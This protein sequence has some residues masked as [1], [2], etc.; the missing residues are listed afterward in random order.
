MKLAIS[1]IA[2]EPAEDAKVAGLM[3]AHGFAGVE[4]APTKYWPQ[5]LAAGAADIAAVRGFWERRGLPIIAMQSLLFGTQGLALFESEAKRRATRDYLAGILAL[6]GKLGAKALVFGSPKNRLKGAL[7]DDQAETIAVPFFRALGEVAVHHHTYLCV[8]PNPAAYGC[9]WITTSA[10]GLALVRK[11][12]H[13]GFGLHLD[14]AGMTL[15]GEDLPEAIAAADRAIRHFHASEAQLAPL[16]KGG[17]D[18]A[19]AAGALRSAG[20]TGWVSI[21]ML[22]TGTADRMAAVEKALD[23]AAAAYGR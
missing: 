22:V 13:P 5:P 8:E 15:A 10:Q 7:T 19:A 11:V 17:T 16:G 4:I 12:D 2:W 6:A 18:H 21:E 1:N 14:A 9:D 23:L 20:Y 3:R